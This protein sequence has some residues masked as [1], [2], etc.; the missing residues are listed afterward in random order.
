M[1]G[2]DAIDADTK[3]IV[4]WFF[5]SRDATSAWWLTRDVCSRLITRVQLT[6][7][8]LT[9]YLPVVYEAFESEIG[10]AQAENHA[11]CSL[12]FVHY[13]VVR[14]HNTLRV[15]PAMEAG[16]ANHVWTIEEMLGL[17]DRRSEVAA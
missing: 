17:W 1:L 16:L 4:S 9:A 13:H 8:G 14:V 15:T 12:H 6:T 3:L 11:A 10:L 2:V 5:G 7:D